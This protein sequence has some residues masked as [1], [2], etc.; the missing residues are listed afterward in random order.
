MNKYG[1]PI[2]EISLYDGRI[3]SL[4]ELIQYPTYG[5]VLCGFPDTTMNQLHIERA[6]KDGVDRFKCQVIPMQPELY[7]IPEVRDAY[8][9]VYEKIKIER[10]GL[11][12]CLG[13]FRSHETPNH[14]EY[15]YSHL[16]ILWYQDDLAMPISDY[17]IQQIHELAWNV[18][19]EGG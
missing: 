8:I 1:Y 12:T 9:D 17:N 16:G 13:L 10:I 19:A 14:P 6:I 5:N 18:L 7:P 3:I 4:C 15:I 2:Y 11:V